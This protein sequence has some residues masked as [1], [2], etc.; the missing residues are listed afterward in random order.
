MTLSAGTNDHFQQGPLP[1]NSDKNKPAFFLGYLF[2]AWFG[3]TWQVSMSLCIYLS[4]YLLS[5]QQ[6]HEYT[7]LHSMFFPLI[8]CSQLSETD[9]ASAIKGKD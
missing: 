9:K 3:Y 8:C 4:P 7:T 5:Y 1:R 2:L 6:C